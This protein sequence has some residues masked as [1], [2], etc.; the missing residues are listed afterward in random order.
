[1]ASFFNL[2]LDTLA[3]SGLSI[4]L[5]NG[6]LYTG[7]KVVNL[8]VAV[9]DEDTTGYQMK[10]WGV[11]GVASEED[12][13]WETYQTEKS[14]TLPNTD[15]LKTV[16]VK[17]RDDVGNEAAVVTANITLDTTAPVVSVVGPDVSKIS[18]VAGFDTA[19]ISFTV[20]EQFK[21]YK[22]CYVTTINGQQDAGV[23]I[24]TNNG[25]ANTSGTKEDGYEANVSINVTIKGADLQAVSA[26]DGTKILKVFAQDMA[27]NWSVA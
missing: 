15:G 18:K 7:N 23:I 20:N 9:S 25:S 8:A 2:I 4:L 22:V 17:V 24:P 14:I 10:I 11:D 27:G 19:T 1:M 3:P 13:A 5:N 12:A 6:A 16:S 21:A 26:S